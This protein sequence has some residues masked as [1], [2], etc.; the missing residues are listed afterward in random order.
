MFFVN[1]LLVPCYT[2]LLT[3][4]LFGPG[5]RE[6]RGVLT[7][8][9]CQIP[10]QVAAVGGPRSQLTDAFIELTGNFSLFYND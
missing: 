3:M 2:G 4:K 7:L 5:R 6:V 8:C 10:R 9:Q 1:D